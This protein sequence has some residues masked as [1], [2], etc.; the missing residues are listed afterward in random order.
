MCEA[1]EATGW[2]SRLQERGYASAAGLAG[3]AIVGAGLGLNPPALLETLETSY[4]GLSDV[5]VLDMMPI[6]RRSD[7]W[8]MHLG[9]LLECRGD[10]GSR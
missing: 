5:Y 1:S 6:C 7:R 9:P 2:F 10:G 3:V 8:L 4:F